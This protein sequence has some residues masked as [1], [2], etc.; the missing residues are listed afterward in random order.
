MG[1]QPGLDKAEK[2]MIYVPYRVG[3]L[4]REPLTP[5]KRGRVV[6]SNDLEPC[7]LGARITTVSLGIGFPVYKIGKSCSR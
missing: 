3:P 6:Y 5:L 7:P 2:E 1:I 4:P